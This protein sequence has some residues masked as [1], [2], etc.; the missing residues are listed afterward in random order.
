MA[1]TITPEPSKFESTA[2]T[3]LG[4]V[5]VVVVGVLLF[6]YFRGSSPFSKLGKTESESSLST[7]TLETAEEGK[8]VGGQ[9]SLPAKYTVQANDNL[10]Q[11]SLKFYGTGYNWVDI[12][13]ENNLKSPNIISVNQ[14]LTIPNV[15]AK[16]AIKTASKEG[17]ITGNSYTVVKGDN[18]WKISVRAYQ[19]GFKWSEIAKANHLTNPNVIHAGSELIIPR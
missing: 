17:T 7:K 3:I 18:L 4:I 5:V 10:W 19:D 6:N 1:K 2:S 14:E 11:I 9:T 8:S 16:I 13:R 12:S 15:P